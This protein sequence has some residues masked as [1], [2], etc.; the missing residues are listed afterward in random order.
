M[1]AD[2][3]R[4]MDLS[5]R[6]EHSEE[7]RVMYLGAHGQANAL[8]VLL[9]AAKI[10][11]D[12][13]VR[14]IEFILVGDG[15]EKPKLTELARELG[16]TNVEFRDAVSKK[17]APAVLC[18]ADACVFTLEKVEV[19]G[20]GISSNK[21]FDYMAAVKPVIFA[22]DASNN[23]VEEARCGLT[24]PPRDPQALA[25]VI[26]QLHQMRKEERE[27]MGRHGREY[28]EK[29]HSIPVL[30]DKLETCLEEVMKR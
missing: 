1:G 30:T 19:F 13:G 29:H 11:R 25:E 20:Y 18:E 10:V 28:V 3:S 4:F 21:L 15:P 6:E 16:L 26:I 23:P 8:D 14:G 17:E 24:V 2:L 7:F 5:Q 27:A 22:V 12:K 9:Q